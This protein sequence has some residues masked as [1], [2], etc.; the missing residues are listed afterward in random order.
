VANQVQGV[1]ASVKVLELNGLPEKG[2]V[3]NWLEAG[4]RAEDLEILARN[5]PE[6]NLN[7]TWHYK[8]GACQVRLSHRVSAGDLQRQ[9]LSGDIPPIEKLPLLGD[10]ALSPFVGE[11]AH[12]LSGYPKTGKTELLVRL[13]MEWSR[14]GLPVPYIT[15]EPELVWA[16]RLAR[17]PEG[18]EN[19]QLIFGM[20]Y[21]QADVEGS[22]VAGDERIVIVDTI[23]LLRIGDEND[24][25][26][27]NT[28]LTPLITL[29]RGKKQTLIMAHHTRKGGG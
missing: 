16:A 6:W 15:E 7:L 24:N 28:A 9:A 17:L 4:N 10:S 29:C 21:T 3:L 1:A 5:C 8:N 27:L 25:S 26:S 12:L 20:G 19:V 18:F 13:A 22:I 11:W 23:R 2:D 14:A